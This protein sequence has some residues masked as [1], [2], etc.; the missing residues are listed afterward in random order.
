MKKALLLIFLFF[1]FH[2][3][4]A[5]EKIDIPKYDWSWKGF[6]ELMTAPQLNEV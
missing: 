5:G 6:L 2:S 3:Y 1:S 4:G